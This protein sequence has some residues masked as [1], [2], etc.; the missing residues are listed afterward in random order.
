M[1][2]LNID[3]DAIDQLLYWVLGSRFDFFVCF[4]E[5]TQGS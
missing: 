4:H 2:Y 1:Y 3:D 5:N